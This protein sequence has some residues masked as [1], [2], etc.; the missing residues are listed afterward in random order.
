M[1]QRILIHFFEMP[2]AMINMNLI[3]DLPHLL[4]QFLEIFYRSF[5]VL[6]AFSVVGNPESRRFKPRRTQGTQR[7]QTSRMA[8]GGSWPFLC[9]LKFP[10]FDGQGG[11]SLGKET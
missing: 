9:A 8:A 10:R 2:V 6:S 7:G 11:R 4:R 3:R 1:G 5:F